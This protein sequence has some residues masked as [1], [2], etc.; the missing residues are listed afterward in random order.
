M[1]RYNLHQGPHQSDWESKRTQSPI[2]WRERVR[3][4]DFEFDAARDDSA[5]ALRRGRAVG[6]PNRT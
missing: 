2:I 3:C 4:A 1:R 6:R 5:A